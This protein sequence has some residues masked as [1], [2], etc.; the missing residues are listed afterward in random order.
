MEIKGI[1]KLKGQT[2]QVSDKFKK[3]KFVVT[4]DADSKY[5]QQV[6]FVASQDKC[7]LLDNF[8]EGQS[9]TVHFNLRGREWVNNQG[10]AKYFNSLEAWRIDG[11]SAAGKPSAPTFDTSISDNLPF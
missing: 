5:P 2:Q 4:T 7:A 1:L 11:D 3:R 6:Q 9:V 8:S 10:E